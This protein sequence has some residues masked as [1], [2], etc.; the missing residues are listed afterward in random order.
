[1]LLLAHTRA[2]LALE[3]TDGAIDRVLELTFPTED[4]EPWGWTF[5][6]RLGSVWFETW[7]LSEDGGLA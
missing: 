3:P 4:S 5:D 6:S 1:M 7:R 2:A